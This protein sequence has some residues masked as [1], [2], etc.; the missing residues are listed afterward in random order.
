MVRR[1]SRFRKIEWWVAARSSRDPHSWSPHVSEIR[2]AVAPK[3]RNV[4]IG[5]ALTQQNVHALV[6]QGALNARARRAQDEDTAARMEDK[7]ALPISIIASRIL[8]REIN[9]QIVS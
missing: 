4:G 7:C 8:G 6:V 9:R 3:R 2:V 1:S 5:R